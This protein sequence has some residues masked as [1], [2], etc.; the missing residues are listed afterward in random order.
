[1]MINRLTIPV[2]RLVAF[3]AVLFTLSACGGGGGGDGGFL[4]DD[5]SSGTQYRLELALTDS[6]GQPTNAVTATAPI[7]LTVTVTRRGNGN[8]VAD[9]VV[10]AET[11]IGM[12]MP[13][14]GSA[15][16]NSNGNATF[17][18]A[19]GNELGAG[20]ANVSVNSP[21]A[22]AAPF[23]ESINFQVGQ[24]GLRL[25][26]FAD[27]AFINGAIGTSATDISVGGSTL[28]RFA[29]VDEN[30]DLAT[31]VETIEIQSGCSLSGLADLPAS[32]ET[33][34][35]QA[36]ATYTASGCSGNDE[37]TAS[38]AS[39][40]AIAT[41]VLSVAPPEA[42]VIEFVA[43][44]PDTGIIA[45]KGTGTAIR[46]EKATVTFRVVSGEN[47][48]AN[49]GT[50]LAGIPVRFTISTDVGGIQLQNA[51]GITDGD[52]QVRATVQSGSVST[53]VTVTAIIETDNGDGPSTASP[54]IVVST[55]LPDQNSISIS[56]SVLNVQ[57]GLDF[58][59]RTADITVRLADKFNNPVADG[60]S[61][62]FTTE[63]GSIVSSC[64]TVDGACTV[65]WTSQDPRLPVFNQDLVRTIF[66]G[67]YDCPPSTTGSPGHNGNRGPC[68][69]DLGGIRGLRTTILVTVVGEEFFVDS[70]G[71]GL[72]DEGEP[73]ENL[74]EAFVDHNE[75]NVY[76]PVVGPNCNA[77]TTTERCEAAGSEETF[78]DFDGDGQYSLN[79]EE[80][81]GDGVYNGS[82]CPLEGDGIWCSR[83][84]VNVRDDIVLIMSSDANFYFTLVN[85]LTRRV[86]ARTDEAQ[87]FTIYVSDFYNNRPAGGLTVNVE[88]SGGCTLL[89][90]GS[91]EVPGSNAPGAFG[92]PVEA[93]GD[94]ENGTI[95]VS[96]GASSQT[97]GCWTVADPELP[98]P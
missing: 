40:S 32:V 65:T 43:I 27:G 8:P 48:A 51:T 93:E 15:L 75:D 92:V 58:D 21:D 4:P 26:H 91:F 80:G 39:N 2:G 81:G 11:N 70:N 41:T 37:I 60:T 85:D 72:Y 86:V 12:L 46:P 61:A 28:L 57:G 49:P 79:N 20:T 34:N 87:R 45:L 95:T 73:F 68:P 1:M 29:V 19:A 42:D 59:G 54:P 56:A 83:E 62:V 90:P 74:P 13:T 88:A 25:G 6:S 64:V 52:G 7:T 53:S 14:T 50:P 24:A 47:T 71:N 55:G 16:T 66:D 98:P 77:S 96:I 18:I 44:S 69:N 76:T 30:G 35:G 22:G 5:G 94:G 17:Q 36:T 67:D 38:L 84:L 33:V 63:Y 78:V 3:C 31:T 10:N 97:F 9:A 82:L 23:T 89:T